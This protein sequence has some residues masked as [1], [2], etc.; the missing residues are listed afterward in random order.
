M[1][2]TSCEGNQNSQRRKN[3]ERGES[4][5]RARTHLVLADVPR[6][7]SVNHANLLA[8]V[9][10]D[11]AGEGEEVTSHELRGGESVLRSVGGEAGDAAGL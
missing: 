8:L 2:L 6:L 9:D 10:D 11:G 4:R 5:E 1:V 3:E 7:R